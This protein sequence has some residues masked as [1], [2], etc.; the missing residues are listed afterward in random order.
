MIDLYGTALGASPN[1]Y[2]VVLLLEE[3]ELP[4]RLIPLD[5]RA[6]EQFSPA[7]LSIGLFLGWLGLI[8]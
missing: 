4:Y 3:L 1:V 7:F 5:I 6:G 2:K 8:H